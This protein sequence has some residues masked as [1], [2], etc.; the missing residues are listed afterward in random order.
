MVGP[1]RV[2]RI[3]VRDGVHQEKAFPA[4]HVLL[5]HSTARIGKEMKIRRQQMDDHFDVPKLFLACRVQ[6]VHQGVVSV[7]DTLFP[8]RV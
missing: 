1:D 8:V 4:M 7:N 6:D 2:E 5:T 3:S